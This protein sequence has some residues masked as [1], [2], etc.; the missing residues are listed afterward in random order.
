MTFEKK[1]RVKTP[2]GVKIFQILHFRKHAPNMEKRLAKKNFIGREMELGL[3]RE[4]LLALV[5]VLLLVVG[6]GMERSFRLIVIRVWF[7]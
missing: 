6:L 3:G 4:I 2:Y 1:V 7:R 5:V